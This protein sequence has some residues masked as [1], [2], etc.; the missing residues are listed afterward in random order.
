[1]MQPSPEFSSNPLSH[2]SIALQEPRRPADVAY[3]SLTIAAMLLLLV[4]L[5]VF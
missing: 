2:P 3:Q 1:M 5:W 4:S